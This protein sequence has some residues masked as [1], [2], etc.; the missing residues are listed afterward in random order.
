MSGS[1]MAVGWREWLRLPDL[2]V[3]LVKTKIDTGAR[4]SAIHADEVVRVR[5]RGRDYVEF[6]IS[7]KQ[8]SHRGS[9]RASA[10]LLDER[11]IRSSNGLYDIRP[12]IET[13]IDV[14]GEIWP[15]ELTLARRDL[16]GFRMLLG[17]QAMRGR[18]L[19]DPSRSYLTRRVKV[20]NKSPR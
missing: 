7:P 17:R 6:T 1:L 15:I 8:R 12:V 9:V 14:G 10:R 11:R 3:R 13:H 19:V 18:L 16:M 4:S 20:K 5:R 2:G